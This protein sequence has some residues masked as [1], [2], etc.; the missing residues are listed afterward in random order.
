MEN[1]TLFNNLNQLSSTIIFLITV[2]GAIFAM[3]KFM[4]KDVIK[5]I[6]T[7]DE[8]ISEIKEENKQMEKRWIETNKRMDG[9]YHLLLKRIKEE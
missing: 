2:C 5:A 3:M 1:T 9:V 4:L 6:Q 7:M 8:H